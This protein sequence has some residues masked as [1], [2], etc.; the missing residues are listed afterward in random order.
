MN[1]VSI[2]VPLIRTVVR[3]TRITTP[4]QP[5]S[6]PI[7]GLI[8]ITDETKGYQLVPFALGRPIVPSVL[9]DRI[10][11]QRFSDEVLFSL[12]LF[13]PFVFFLPPRLSRSLISLSLPSIFLYFF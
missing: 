9:G 11:R 13:Y 10:V 6:G 7:K 3:D 4:L 2:P 5:R 1:G 12:S 8:S